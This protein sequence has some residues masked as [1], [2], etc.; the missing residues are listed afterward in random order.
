MADI[1]ETIIVHDIIIYIIT[2]WYVYIYIWIY[3]YIYIHG[4]YMSIEYVISL[5][6]IFLFLVSV[7]KITVMLY[8]D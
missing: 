5:F 7:M 6:N 8:F 2:T 1:T 3:M 4:K